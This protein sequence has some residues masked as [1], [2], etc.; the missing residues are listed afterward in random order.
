MFS[1]L[2]YIIRPVLSAPLTARK[3]GSEGD[4]D[5]DGENGVRAG[6]YFVHRRGRGCPTTPQEAMLKSKQRENATGRV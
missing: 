2:V 3:L 1:V 4:G 6:G 5:V